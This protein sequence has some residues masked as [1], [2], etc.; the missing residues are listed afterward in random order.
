MYRVDLI[1]LGFLA[2]LDLDV[3]DLLGELLRRDCRSTSSSGSSSS[4]S[5]SSRCCLFV[6]EVGMAVVCVVMCVYR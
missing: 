1:A 5:S 4:S 3:R 2:R 6:V